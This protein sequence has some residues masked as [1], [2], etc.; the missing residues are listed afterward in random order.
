[1]LCK[2]FLI[3]K[4]KKKTDRLF[5]SS[6]GKIKNKQATRFELV[7]KGWKPFV[8]PLHHAC[9]V[10]KREIGKGTKPC[11]LHNLWIIRS[12][13]SDEPRIHHQ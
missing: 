4:S 12:R 13:V 1:M 8:L 6:V 3:V 7:I 5:T 10:K 9:D 2:L 11:S